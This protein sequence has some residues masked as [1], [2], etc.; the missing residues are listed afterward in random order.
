[1]CIISLT[2]AIYISVMQHLAPLLN[3]KQVLASQKSFSIAEKRRCAV[4]IWVGY[5]VVAIM[6]TYYAVGKLWRPGTAF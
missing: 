2:V 1:M 5:R 4:G 6:T 3:I